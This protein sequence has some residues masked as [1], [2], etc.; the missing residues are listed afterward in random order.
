MEHNA[1]VFFYKNGKKTSARGYET[2]INDHALSK[3]GEGVKVALAKNISWACFP[4]RAAVY[5]PSLEKIFYYKISYVSYYAN[6]RSKGEGITQ[7]MTPV[8]K[9]TCARSKRGGAA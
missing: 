7:G 5:I 6:K 2:S 9:F 4:H 3:G 1:T 8:Y